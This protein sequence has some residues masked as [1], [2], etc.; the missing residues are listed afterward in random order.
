MKFL[1]PNEN[2]PPVD[3]ATKD[4]ILAIGGDLSVERLLLA[5][6]NGIFPWYEKYEPIIWWSPDPR[7]V[8]FPEKLKVS[9]S[10]QRLFRKKAF[11][12]TFNQAFESVIKNCAN[13]K[14]EGQGGTWITG[15]IIDAYTN[16]HKLGIAHSV[17]VWQSGKLV[18]G[19]YGILLQEKKM[20]CGESM[21]S[22]VSNA[23]KYGF[24]T[25]IERLK[26]IDVKLLDCQVHTNHL[27]SLGAEEIPR[28]EFLRYLE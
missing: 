8:L 23:S 21:F 26:A 5:Y 2:F 7:M 3:T 22:K 6:N 11:D 24:I 15:E 25:L 18:G 1:R 12:V 14:R 9:R 27:Q 10:M 28:K 17:E 13:I 20:F 4:G 19:V 16:L